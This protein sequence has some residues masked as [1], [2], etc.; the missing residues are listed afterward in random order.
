MRA[1]L[2]I[3]WASSRVKP[4]AN[5]PRRR[6]AVCSSAD[7]TVAPFECGAQ[8]W[9][10]PQFHARAAGQYVELLVEP[11]V[12]AIDTE[13]RHARRGQFNGQRNAVQSPAYVDSGLRRF[14]SESKAGI[15]G[16]RAFNEECHSAELASPLQAARWPVPPALRADRPAHRG[17]SAIPAR[18]PAALPSVHARATGRSTERCRPQDARSCRVPI[19]DSYS[20]G[21]R[22]ATSFGGRPEDNCIPSAPAMLVGTCAPSVAGANSTHHRP[23]GSSTGSRRSDQRHACFADAAGADNRHYRVLA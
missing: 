3:C 7:K 11:R 19:A 1:S 22:R 9:C 4:P 23:S 2:T 18:S 12:Q 20:P 8:V 15:D 16:V 10:L 13:Q 14:V 17:T 6:N 5:T 21:P